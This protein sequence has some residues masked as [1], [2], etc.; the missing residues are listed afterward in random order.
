LNIYPKF[1]QG[2]LDDDSAYHV[3]L[4][5]DDIRVVVLNGYTY[6]AAHDYVDD[7]VA[8]G[9]EIARSDALA[10]VTVTDGTFDHANETLL[11]V[12][13]GQTITDVIWF[14]Y[15]V[16]DSAAI[17]ICHVDEDSN[18]NPLSLSTNGSD[19]VVTPPAAGVFSLV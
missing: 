15:N 7:V 1:A 9:T 13:N 10:S 8:A 2:L 19:V 4:N 3:D 12:A 6:N 17:L 5:T 11:A 14:K 16:L 18:G